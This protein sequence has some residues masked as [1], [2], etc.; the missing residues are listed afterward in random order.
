MKIGAKLYVGAFIAAGLV[1]I[2]YALAHWVCPEP[3]HFAFH[4]GMAMVAAGLKVNLPGIAGTMSVSYVFVLLTILDFSYPEAMVVA[5]LSMVVQ[6]VWHTRTRPRVVH[7][8]FNLGSAAITVTVAEVLYRIALGSGQISLAIATAASFYFFPTTLS[9]A[10]V[11][12]LTE[13]K[14]IR[15]V[16]QE[17]YMWSFPYNLVGGGIAAVIS[18]CNRKLGW[19]TT[20]LALPVVYVI[21]RSYRLYLGKLESEKLHAEQI[22]ELHLR[23]IEALALAIEAKD[24]TTCEHIRRVQVYA[25]ELARELGLDEAQMQ[26]RCGPAP[27]STISENWRSRNTS[28]PSRGNSPTKSSRK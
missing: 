18:L 12:A 20:V 27:F 26:R 2:A 7:T 25:V 5:C 22:A 23:T 4:L 14:R 3:Y 11:V 1:C 19:Q 6:S 24:E 9:V 15:Q 16:W 28:S 21:F 13:S 17:A 10:G 8:L